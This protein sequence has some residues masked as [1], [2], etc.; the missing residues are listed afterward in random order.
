MTLLSVGMRF[1]SRG[2]VQLRFRTLLLDL[3]LDE[4]V[5]LIGKYD[6]LDHLVELQISDQDLKPRALGASL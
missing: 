1:E 2:F 5:P 6:Q 4:F 3:S